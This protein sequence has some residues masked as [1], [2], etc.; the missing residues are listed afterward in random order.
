MILL[1]ATICLQTDPVTLQCRTEVVRVEPTAAACHRMLE[2][3][4]AW[5]NETYAPAWLGI[6]CKTG[7]MG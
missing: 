5:L 7:T 6:A 4:A 1:V 2:P 3:T